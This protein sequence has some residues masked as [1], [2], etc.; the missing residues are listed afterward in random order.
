MGLFSDFESVDDVYKSQVMIDFLK[1]GSEEKEECKSC[2]WRRLCNGG[3]R[4]DC[5]YEGNI[6]SNYFCYSFKEF[7]KHP[8]P[9]LEEIA[10]L[11]L[12]YRRRG[13]V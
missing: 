3:C 7:F 13:G 6:G 1:E 9:R 8:Y 4:R 2:Q 11:E 10:Q 12:E 5:D